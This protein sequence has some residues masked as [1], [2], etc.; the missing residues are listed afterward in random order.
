MADV[1]EIAQSAG[2]LLFRK[3]RG[4]GKRAMLRTFCEAGRIRDGHIAG[5][6]AEDGIRSSLGLSMLCATTSIR[7]RRSFLLEACQGVF[8]TPTNASLRA[9]TLAAEAGCRNPIRGSFADC[10]ASAE[11]APNS[12]KAVMRNLLYTDVSSTNWLAPLA[13]PL[14]SGYTGRQEADHAKRKI[15]KP[16][17]HLWRRDKSRYKPLARESDYISR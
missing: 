12:I 17:N 7:M 5:D 8:A 3:F 13:S 14:R 2:K 10:C 16:T 4:P 15:P 11:R 1:P 9:E 6:K